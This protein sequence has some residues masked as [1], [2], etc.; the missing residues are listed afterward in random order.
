MK[1]LNDQYSLVTQEYEQ[2]N[3]PNLYETT[4]K[5][6]EGVSGVRVMYSTIMD[7]VRQQGLIH[8]KCLYS[9]TFDSLTQQK[10]EL[11]DEYSAFLSQLR[12]HSVNVQSIAGK[13]M[14]LVE[15]LVGSFGLDAVSEMPWASGGVQIWI[16][17]YDLRLV[18]SKKE[19]QI[20]HIT[21]GPLANFFH[22]L[23]EKIR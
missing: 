5:L 3:S 21:S 2:L 23:V 20:I 9:A 14:S 15:D 12:E 1:Q 17:G 10:K 4:I 6:Y 7:T 8:I 16:V 18:V 19:P 13:G 11:F 22:A